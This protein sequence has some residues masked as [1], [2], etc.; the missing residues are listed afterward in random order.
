M[1]KKINDTLAGVPA[2]IIAGLFLLLDLVPH[3]I[4]EF[5]GPAVHLDFLPFDPAWVTVIISGIPML[6]LAV[7]RVIH[8]PGISKISSALLISIAMIAA[9]AIGDLFAAGEVAWIMA[10]GAILEDMTTERAK[11]GLKK[12][13]SLAPTQGRRI[14][15]GKE[16]MIPAE[17]IGEGDVLRILPG[18]TI[19]VD[20]MI[21]TG[22]TSVDQSIMTGESLPVDKAVGDDVFCGTINRFGSIDIRATKVG[23]D[24]SLQ[25]LIRMVQEAEDKKAPMA[26]IA[27]KAASWLV[28]AALMI[29]VIAGIVTK[30]IVRAVTVLV[31][32]CPC[33]LV[34][35]TPTAIMAAIGQATRHGVIIKSGEALE[36]MGKVNTVAFD[37]TGTLT[38]G[39]LEV[40]D[41]ISFDETIDENALLSLA[42]SAE[43]KSEHPLG[44]AIFACAKTRGIAVIESGAFRMTAGK[45][46]YAEVSGRKLFCGNED[47]LAENGAV[48]TDEVRETVEAL[49][50]QG[51]ASVIAA[52]DGRCIGVLAMSDILRPEAKGM[53]DR[54]HGMNT[55]IVLL[56][57][58][59]Q[60]T[61]DYFA[62]QVG[63]RQIRAQLLPEEKVK[64]ITEIQNEGKTVCMI[65]DGVNDAPALKTANVGVAM[66]GLGSDIAVEAA[67]VVLISDDISKL[68]YL[69]RLSNATVG[70]I[71]FSI[72]LSMLI[73]ILAVVLSVRGVLN[74]TTGA[75]V[76]NAGSCFVVLIA[77]LLYDRKFE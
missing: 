65:G 50:T 41:V 5:G 13:I 30:D 15:N 25:K 4:E 28:P 12:L 52:E 57:G 67:D 66:G 21:L 26:R 73:N 10:I 29:A 2:T 35:A 39:R 68:P 76:H 71:K 48:L 20:G 64:S 59:N 24:S 74:P 44:K 16:E 55:D 38:Y 23:E 1:L 27:D 18:E 62:E 9:I 51:K 7:W 42:A 36:K 8:N 69:K 53:V 40:S 75:L 45:G 60:K 77:A 72:T 6:Y 19:P 33:A 70:T 34:L 31:V 63:I 11:K 3:I 32:F 58:D 61:A 47:Y 54:L 56:T 43:A 14:V 37:K 49:R 17:K 22:E 46:I